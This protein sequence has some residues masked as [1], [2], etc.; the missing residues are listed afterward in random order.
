MTDAM[1]K[2]LG[3]LSAADIGTL[4]YTDIRKA[5]GV[6][7]RGWRV[8]CRRLVD[9]GMAEHAPYCG[10]PRLTITAEGKAAI[11]KAEGRS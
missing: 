3:A 6:T 9:T 5:C 1:R 8:I 2:A 4:A 7:W 10:V 11:A